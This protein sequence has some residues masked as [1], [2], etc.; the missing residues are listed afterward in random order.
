MRHARLYS[1]RWNYFSFPV[2][3]GVVSS[4]K[5]KS[6]NDSNSLNL[7]KVEISVGDN[8]PDILKNAEIDIASIAKDFCG[9]ILK[10]DA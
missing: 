1:F 10:S 2:E 6:R 3:I 8:R 9:G 4:S 7:W 5:M